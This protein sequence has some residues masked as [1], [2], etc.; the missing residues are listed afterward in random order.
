MCFNRLMV[1]DIDAVQTYLINEAHSM[2]IT[3]HPG[4]T[5]MAKLLSAQYYWPGMPNDY[6]TFVVTGDKDLNNDDK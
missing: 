4:K 1:P 2:P 6:A 5:K 3:A